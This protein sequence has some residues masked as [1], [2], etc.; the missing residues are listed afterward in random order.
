MRIP[1]YGLILIIVG[2]ITFGTALAA[3]DFGLPTGIPVII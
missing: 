1:T 3:T 2:G